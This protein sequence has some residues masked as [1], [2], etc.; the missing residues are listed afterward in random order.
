MQRCPEQPGR[1]Q[2][3]PPTLPRNSPHHSPLLR[4]PSAPG[5][6]GHKRETSK[7]KA[8]TVSP[9]ANPTGKPLKRNLGAGGLLGDELTEGWRERVSQR[10]GGRTKWQRRNIEETRVSEAEDKLTNPRRAEGGRRL[11][12]QGHLHNTNPTGLLEAETQT[13]ASPQ[14][15]EDIPRHLPGTRLGCTPKCSAL[16]WQGSQEGQSSQGLRP[17]QIPRILEGCPKTSV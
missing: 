5:N 1:L 14:R 16:N 10:D 3:S 7:C 12:R 4:K 13:R 8:W 15:P 9:E 11:G 6:S 17:Q 2:K